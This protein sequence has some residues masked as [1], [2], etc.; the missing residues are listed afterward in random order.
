LVRIAAVQNPAR[1][2]RVVAAAWIALLT[3]VAGGAGRADAVAHGASV[4]DGKYA[5]AVKI[6]YRGIPVLGGG[7]R[8]S[9][10]SGGLIS[11]HWV[12]TAGHCFRD[13]R[14]VRVSRPVARTTIATVGRA[15]LDGGGGHDVRVIAVRQN[16]TVDVALAKLDAAITDVTPMRLGRSA[17][18]VGQRVRL[19]GYGFTTATATKGPQ[20]LR[21]GAF[22]VVSVAETEIGMSGVHP[23]KNTS[24]CPHDSGGPYFTE[25]RDGTA[26]VVGV[27]SHGP[28][29]PHTGADRASR[30]DSIAAW[31][32]TVIGTDEPASP[33]PRPSSTTTP[34][35]VAG[36]NTVG[37][38][39]LSFPWA[40]A[41]AVAAVLVVL[42]AS[43]W[44]RTARR[45]RG[46]HR[47]RPNRRTPETRPIRGR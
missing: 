29:C 4:P 41:G 12:L 40:G 31:I 5:F 43:L 42:T 14:Y 17:P 15:D 47:R 21:T 11:P 26:T 20:R 27:V 1:L 38:A 2:G 7:T 44:R 28:D 24:P 10:C 45:G 16:R 25:G 22:Q 23:A 46:A 35:T 3:A 33:H 13:A 30:I 34:S 39:V 32:R 18:R 6:A 37:P 8:N 19:T 9:S 36:P